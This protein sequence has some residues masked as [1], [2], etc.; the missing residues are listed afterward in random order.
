MI[1]TSV[2]IFSAKVFSLECFLLYSSSFVLLEPEGKTCRNLV[3]DYEKLVGDYLTWI[4]VSSQSNCFYYRS[5]IGT[6]V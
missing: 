4:P 6:M 3:G 2:N 1:I 5:I